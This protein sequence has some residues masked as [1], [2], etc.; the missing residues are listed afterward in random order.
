MLIGAALRIAIIAAWAA[1]IGTHAA[2]HLGGA[3]APLPPALEARV[4]QRLS[5]A[6]IVERGAGER[7]AGVCTWSCAGEHD[8]LRVRTHASLS[9]ASFIPGFSRLAAALG[10][11]TDGREPLDLDLDETHDAGGAITRLAG[12]ARAFGVTATGSGTLAADGL[13]LRWAMPGVAEG[14]AHHDAP[15]RGEVS[16]ALLLGA[17]PA[18]LRPGQ[19][20]ALDLLGADPATL[21]PQARRATFRV[22]AEVEEATPLGQRLLLPV[23]EEDPSGHGAKYWCDSTGLVHRARSD[24]LGLTFELRTVGAEQGAAP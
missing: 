8:G 20:F 9:D 2:R 15:R 24:A 5:Y 22:L 23:E 21:A 1:M 13:E 11:S 6:V 4:G 10:G 3:G 16:A 19:R 14:S 12:E 7:L 18:N 17:L